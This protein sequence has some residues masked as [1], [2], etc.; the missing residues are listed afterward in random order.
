MASLNFS[1]THV[2]DLIIRASTEVNTRCVV[3]VCS[4]FVSNFLKIC[5]L[6]QKLFQL[7]APTLTNQMKKLCFLLVFFTATYYSSNA[8]TPLFKVLGDMEDVEKNTR[9]DFPKEKIGG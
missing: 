3:F 7:N 1:F 9:Y 4:P 2:S 5:S 8:Q 6:M